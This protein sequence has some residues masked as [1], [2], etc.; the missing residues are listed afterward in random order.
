MLSLAVIYRRVWMIVEHIEKNPER[1]PIIV[2][3]IAI[4]IVIVIALRQCGLQD[5]ELLCDSF[6]AGAA[7]FI[8]ESDELPV[9]MY[10]QQSDGWWNPHRRIAQRVR[11]SHQRHR[12]RTR[13][14]GN[15]N[16]LIACK[17]K[18][19]FP[20]LWSSANGPFRYFLTIWFIF[21]IAGTSQGSVCRTT[22][23]FSEGAHRRSQGNIVV[24]HPPKNLEGSWESRKKL[25][26]G[27]DFQIIWS[28]KN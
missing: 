2:I 23:T 26:T 22:G 9:R 14:N 12:R 21:Q 6:I 3:V 18:K 13:S 15:G 28:N 1:I 4:I 11:S 7:Q 25:D 24:E 27:E 19:M 16:C 20:A 10:R 8:D 5:F 17:I